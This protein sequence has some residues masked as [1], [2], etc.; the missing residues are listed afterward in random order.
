MSS[1][2]SWPASGGGAALAD[3]LARYAE[4]HRHYHTLAHV[5]A[6][7]A[8]LPA[9]GEALR[10]AAWYHDAIYDAKSN[11]NEERSADLMRSALSVSDDIKGEAARLILL[12][13]THA[14]AAD[15]RDGLALLDADLAVLGAADDVYD[16]YAAAIRRE[17]AWVPEEAYRKGRAD[18]LRRFLGRERIYHTGRMRGREAAAR[19]N[20]L[21]E[22]GRL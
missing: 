18:V 10:F 13:K 21:R 20:L 19:A 4:P 16:G 6:V 2:E 1:P 15:D 8:E 11:D 3:L 17:Y 7:L 12:T 22:L 5:R 14:A 9:A